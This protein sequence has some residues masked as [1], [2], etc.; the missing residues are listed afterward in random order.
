MFASGDCWLPRSSHF[1]LS[2]LFL[3]RSSFHFLCLIKCSPW[4]TLNCHRGSFQMSLNRRNRFKCC[5]QSF[6]VL[7]NKWYQ[8]ALS[9][10]PQFFTIRNMIAIFIS[11]FF[12]LGSSQKS[13]FCFY[14]CLR[15]CSNSNFVA[16]S[17]V[18]HHSIREKSVRF[19]R[20]R[21]R[22]LVRYQHHKGI[23]KWSSCQIYDA[24]AGWCYQSCFY[25]FWRKLPATFLMILE[26]LLHSMS[27]LNHVTDYGS[28]V[29]Y[30]YK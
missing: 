11:S 4:M 5:L 18:A 17:F 7:I 8:L 13:F 23:S 27:I 22:L 28:W 1:R 21:A 16:V 29:L 12:C 25:L 26:I 20:F 15:D 9:L 10:S 6:Q 19:I 24:S 3:L 2:L 14:Y 30:T